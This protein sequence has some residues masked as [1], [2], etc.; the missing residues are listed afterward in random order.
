V[1]VR[2]HSI[3][4]LESKRLVEVQERESVLMLDAEEHPERDGHCMNGI[5]NMGNMLTPDSSYTSRCLSRA[6]HR[7]RTVRAGRV[8]CTVTVPVPLR[9]PLTIKTDV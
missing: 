6:G 1:V 5:N 2:E 8:R 9:P 7:Y 3:D 4:L